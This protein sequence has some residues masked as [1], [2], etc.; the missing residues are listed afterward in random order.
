MGTEFQF[1]LSW[2]NAFKTLIPYTILHALFPAQKQRRGTWNVPMMMMGAGCKCNRLFF[3]NRTLDDV[4]K[5][6]F[7]DKTC[8]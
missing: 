4:S 8:K 2:I 1:A 7:S 3:V 6:Q 5:I